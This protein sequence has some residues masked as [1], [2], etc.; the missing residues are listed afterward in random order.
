MKIKTFKSSE[1]ANEFIDNHVLLDDGAVQVTGSGDIV[2]FY[3]EHKD[4]FKEQF[5]D[6]MIEGLKRNLFYEETRLITIQAEVD[7]LKEAN[8]ATYP[9]FDE[10]SKKA[11]DAEMHILRFKAKIEALEK[12]KAENTSKK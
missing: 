9:E 7:G 4:K 5:I 11:R 12:W 3:K 1:E 2:V 6:E 8:K 10:N